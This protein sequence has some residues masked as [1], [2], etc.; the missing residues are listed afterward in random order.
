VRILLLLLLLSQTAF[1]QTA[2]SG[3]VTDE[4]QEYIPYAEVMLCTPDSIVLE[5]TRADSAGNYSLNAISLPALL[6]VSA[7][8]YKD[9][10]IAIAAAHKAIF[11]ISVSLQPDDREL[12]VVT[13][14]AARPMLERKADRTVFNVSASV[15]ALGADLYELLRKAPGVSVNDGNIS[16]TGKSSVSVM[17]NNRLVQL[18]GSELA[19]MLRS[20]SADN[21]QKI[22]VITNPPAMYDAEGNA[23]I[24]NIVTKKS[25]QDGFNGGIMAGYQQRTYCSQRFGENFNYRKGK[26]NIYS[27]G[28]T[29][30]FVFQSVQK[31]SVPYAFQQQ[32]QTLEQHNNPLYNRY[33]L[34]VDYNIG[35]NA[36]LGLLYTIGST[37]RTTRQVY[38]GSVNAPDGTLDSLLSTTGEER[39]AA[40]RSVVNLNY[41]RTIDASG[42]KLAVDA[43]YFTRTEHDS[44]DYNTQTSLPDGTA[45][46]SPVYNR[47]TGKQKVDITAFK[48]DITWP[49][50]VADL[51]FGAKAS[52]IHNYSDNRVARLQGS[53]YV[54]DE[55]RN[56][57]FDYRENTQALYISAEKSMGR[58]EGQ[59]GLRGEYTQTRGVSAAAGQTNSNVYFR[60]FPTM[61]LQYQ[62][63]ESNAITLSYSKRIDRPDFQEMNPFRE[64]GT[65]NSYETGNPFLQPSFS[66]NLEL[67]YTYGGKYIFALFSESIRNMYTEAI[68]INP[69]DNSFYYIPDN[70]G[71]MWNAGLSATLIFTPFSWWE[72]NNEVGGFYSYINS[73]YYA[74]KAADN[75]NTGFSFE[76]SNVFMLNK[77]KTLVATL[78]W[79]YTSRQQDELNIQQSHHTLDAGLKAQLL[80]KKLTLSINLFDILRTERYYVRNIY[81]GSLRNSYFDYRSLMATINW[82][83]G[84]SQLKARREHSENEE[85]QRSR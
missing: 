71:N 6:Q 42:K 74:T 66:D 76:T 57:E 7:D 56:N 23:G 78:D 48:A 43:D 79:A 75:G 8:G 21:V 62:F 54:E 16:I 60:L 77:S 84:N 29:N 65:G 39:E 26:L 70:V 15:S 63:D 35:D 55:S 46:N 1:A 22:E 61:Y 17:I 47:N 69:S 58:W 3:T 52:F 34:G 33:Q 40:L 37:N 27:S 11:D 20:M 67:S 44:R 5:V 82:K 38:Q 4:L 53:N 12:Q 28:N 31:T 32:E 14:T 72:S 80:D 13:I 85:L 73:S 68:R 2:I 18:S 81:T 83:F 30:N 10:I 19:A 9:T 64:Y 25:M 59:F 36:I 49:S 51:S 45:V 41:E 50:E 24:I